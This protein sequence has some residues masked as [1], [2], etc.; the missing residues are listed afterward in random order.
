MKF[1]RRRIWGI[2]TAAGAFVLAPLCLSVIASAR[3]YSDRDQAISTRPA[4]INAGK[5][6]GLPDAERQTIAAEFPAYT[7]RKKEQT[8]LTLAEW[9]QVYSYNEF[10][11][12]LA[13]GGRQTDFPFVSAIRNFWVAISSRSTGAT[14]KHSRRTSTPWEK[15]CAGSGTAARFEM[16]HDFRRRII[17]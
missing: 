13:H 17:S 15:R 8:Y 4:A 1:I 9:S 14:G 16:I 6:L 10:G 2:A 3:F 11:D 5:Q 12:F 7:S